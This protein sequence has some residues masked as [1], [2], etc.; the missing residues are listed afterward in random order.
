MT[1]LNTDL[2]TYTLKYPVEFDDDMIESLTFKDLLA[3]DIKET[4]RTDKEIRKMM[5]L[6]STITDVKMSVIESLDAMDFGRISEI[7]TE[8]ME[9]T[10]EVTKLER[11][12][13]IALANPLKLKNGDMI[14]TLSFKRLNMKQI[15][16]S[17]RSKGE[18]KKMIAMIAI[19]SC[20]L[21]TIIGRLS[22]GDYAS[23]CEVVQDFM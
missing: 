11:G 13:E 1:D 10:A 20:T 18:V 15:E 7:I 12:S 6:I 8:L 14:E 16:D 17:Q 9:P 3:S 21:P 5:V 2:K 22:A 4:D 23:A 19:S